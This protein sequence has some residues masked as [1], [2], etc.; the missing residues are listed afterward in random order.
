M[1]KILG[2]DSEVGYKFS[3]QQPPTTKDY[4]TWT[5]WYTMNYNN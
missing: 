2:H 1:E 5:A 3:G 4:Y